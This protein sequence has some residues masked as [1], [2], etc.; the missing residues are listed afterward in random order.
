M[1]N[2]EIL[3]MRIRMNPITN[4][5]DKEKNAFNNAVWESSDMTK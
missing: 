2:L 1:V 5:T 3:A 4:V